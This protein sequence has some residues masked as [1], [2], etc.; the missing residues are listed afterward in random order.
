MHFQ[1]LTGHTAFDSPFIKK[2][3]QATLTGLHK[4]IMITN[5]QG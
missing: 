4:K 3:K 2:E 1:Q 5:M